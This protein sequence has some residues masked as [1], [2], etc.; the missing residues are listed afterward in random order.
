MDEPHWH[1]LYAT[2]KSKFTAEEL[3]P[4]HGQFLAWSKRGDR[5]LAHDADLGELVRLVKA[6]GLRCDEVVFDRI[7]EGGEPEI[8]LCQ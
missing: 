6:L 7:P 1:D 4:Y 5:I 2:N 8:A 3:R